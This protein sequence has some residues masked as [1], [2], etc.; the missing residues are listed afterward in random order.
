MGRAETTSTQMWVPQIAAEPRC[1]SCGSNELVV[2][3]S[4]RLFCAECLQRATPYDARDPYDELG[5]GD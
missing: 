4:A 3:Q 1:L 2:V 5:G